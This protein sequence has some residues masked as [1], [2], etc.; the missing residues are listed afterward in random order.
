MRATGK[1]EGHG[2]FKARSFP[3]NSALFRV[4]WYTS[5]T[6]LVMPSGRSIRSIESDRGPPSPAQGRQTI[7]DGS[8]RTGTVWSGYKA[9]IDP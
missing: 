5:G 8:R 2:C 4:I 1:D 7:D 3:L 9:T 6:R